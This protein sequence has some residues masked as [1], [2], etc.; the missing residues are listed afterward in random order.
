MVAG[1][2]SLW[3][4]AVRL[5]ILGG[6]IGLGWLVGMVVAQVLPARNPEP[7]LA[8]VALR[9]SS[10]TLRKLEQLPAWW[11][12]DGNGLTPAASE[13]GTADLEVPD[14]AVP[15]SESAAPA[16]ADPEA[17]ALTADERLRLRDD[18]TEL[19]QD[20]AGFNA[21]LGE[22]ETAVGEAPV[23]SM[24]DRLQRLDRL[25]AGEASAS[26]EDA[27]RDSSGDIPRDAPSTA[28]GDIPSDGSNG[29]AGDGPD[30]GA[31]GLYQ[32]PPFPLVSDRV[33]LPSAL[34]FEPNTAIL[35][36]PGRQLLD[37]VVPDLRRYGA[38]TL[39]VGSHTVGAPPD[40]ASQ[41]T[42]QQSLA[43]QQ[44]LAPHLEAEGSRWVTVGYGQTRPRTV[45]ATAADQQRN[46][47]VE[48]GIV[49]G[50]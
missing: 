3:T 23:G 36:E 8:E 26:A 19:R 44:H 6:G 31:V 48:I 41:L 21:R 39:L 43:V 13:P 25:A 15:G 28:A 17:P 47:R 30:S 5:T 45:G 20:M 12:G 22:L 10:Q 46:Q 7:P 50:S 9:R 14:S 11:R 2:Q 42:F 29:G 4:W 1:L 27:P 33:V 16:G 32:E 34:L 24:E 38:A 18:L 37:S 49:S 35:T 40:E